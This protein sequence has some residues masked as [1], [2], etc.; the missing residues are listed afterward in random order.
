MPREW[1][2]ER[3][4]GD[5][6]SSIWLVAAVYSF[7]C[8]STEVGEDWRDLRHLDMLMSGQTRPHIQR[9]YFWI[10][11]W[12]LHYCVTITYIC[13]F[14]HSSKKQKHNRYL[15]KW[16]KNWLSSPPNLY[17]SFYTKY[18]QGSTD[19]AKHFWVADQAMNPLKPF[20]ILFGT[21]YISLNILT[22]FWHFYCCTSFQL[23]KPVA[24]RRRKDRG[25]KKM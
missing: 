23:W 1:N 15:G 4:P 12:L 13:H 18:N 21:F 10:S 11:I 16:E 20:R 8:A 2:S 22:F 5:P 19:I 14:H 6:W 3:T 24:Q 17:L 25:N 9:P 7:L